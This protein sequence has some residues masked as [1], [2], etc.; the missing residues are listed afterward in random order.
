MI[1]QFVMYS[2][3]CVLKVNL[4]IKIKI[5]ILMGVGMNV[6]TVSQ[7]L[8]LQQALKVVIQSIMDIAII[9]KKCYQK[10]S[11]QTEYQKFPTGKS[12]QLENTKGIDDTVCSMRL[13]FCPDGKWSDIGY[14]SNGNGK[15]VKIFIFFRGFQNLLPK[16]LW[17]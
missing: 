2:Y 6:M 5:M 17:F 9:T 12:N 1:N 8:I 3:G 7:V 16:A 11:K 14:D 10:L 4:V 15:D 13:N